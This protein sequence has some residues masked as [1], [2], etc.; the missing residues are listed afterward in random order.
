M[1]HRLFLEADS[2]YLTTLHQVQEMLRNEHSIARTTIQVEPF[3]EH[4]MNNCR[5][6]RVPNS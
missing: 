3:D 1:M 4:V 6:C 5:D 2:D